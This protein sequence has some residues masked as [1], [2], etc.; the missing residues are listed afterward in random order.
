MSDHAP[1]SP[2]AG[3]GQGQSGSNALKSSTNSSSRSSHRDSLTMNRAPP[4]PRLNA[5]R[6]SSLTEYFRNVPLSPRAQRAPSM[7][8][9]AIQDF[10]NDPPSAKS[11]TPAFAGRDWRSVRVEEVVDQA[12]VRFAE[13][14]TS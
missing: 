7:S 1:S 3:H 12:K 2:V 5:N 11:G 13:M 6:S 8:Q 14:T 10:L 4:S 9:S